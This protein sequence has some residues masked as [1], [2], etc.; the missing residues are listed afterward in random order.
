MADNTLLNASDGNPVR[1]TH[2][3]V[4]AS[5]FFL[6]GDHAGSAI[7]SALDGL[8]LPDTELTK[9]IAL[10]IGV[11]E[12]GLELG[13]RLGAPF[14][15]QHFSRLVCDCNR[16]PASEEWAP[17]V[18]DGTAIP[19]NRGLSSADL[20]AREKEIFE[21]YH[22][23]IEAALEQRQL[24]GT[25]TVFVSLHSF[26]PDMGTEDRPWEVAV[27]HDGREDAFARDVLNLLRARGGYVVGDNQPYH[28]DDTDYTVPRHAYPRKLPYI[29]LEVRQDNLASEVGIGRMADLLARVLTE[30][31]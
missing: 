8:G 14:T 28:M 21:P 17:E 7:P 22:A 25:P 9:H 16:H 31:L 20:Q 1:K 6:V 19:G 5:P 29:E 30:A 12:L 13:E 11:R 4:T 27:L 18:S 10:D 23:S 3:N 2:V 15:W 26:T 24:K